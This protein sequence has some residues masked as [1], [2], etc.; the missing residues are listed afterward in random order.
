MAHDSWEATAETNCLD[1]VQEFYMANSTAVRNAQLSNYINPRKTINYNPH[2][3]IMDPHHLHHYYDAPQST[4]GYQSKDQ[5]TLGYQSKD[6][7]TL[8]DQSMELAYY[9]QQNDNN[10]RHAVCAGKQR[11]IETP[12]NHNQCLD[13]NYSRGQY[14]NPAENTTEDFYRCLDGFLH[15]HENPHYYNQELSRLRGALAHDGAWGWKSSS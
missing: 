15:S 3:S 14:N 11:Q 8:V 5:S 2:P 4:L 7:S 13:V 12:Y 6:Q 1:L 10:Y 9:N